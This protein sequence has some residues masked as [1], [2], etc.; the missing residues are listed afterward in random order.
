LAFEFANKEG[1]WTIT[2][3]RTVTMNLNLFRTNDMQLL[4]DTTLHETENQVYGMGVAHS[5]NIYNLMNNVFKKVA[6]RIALIT[7]EKIGSPIE[8]K[9]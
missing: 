9:K 5:I 3:S 2:S 6:Q 8:G 4:I 1:W 7:S